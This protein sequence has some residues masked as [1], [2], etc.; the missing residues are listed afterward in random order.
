MKL[1]FDQN[2][3]PRLPRLLADI[4]YLLAGLVAAC[5]ASETRDHYLNPPCQDC[6]SFDINAKGMF[7]VYWYTFIAPFLKAF[8]IL[9]L[10]RLPLL[11]HTNRKRKK[12]DRCSS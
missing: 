6:P 7:R 11:L 9:S 1:L 8:A 5:W 2:L 12:E 3:S 10:I 4:F